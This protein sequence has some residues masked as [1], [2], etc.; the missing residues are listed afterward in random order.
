MA[1]EYGLFWN[2]RGG[3]RKY[4]AD[5]FSD[6]LK[7]FFTTGVFNGDLFV[8][9]AE[10]MDITVSPGYVN[11]DGKVMMWEGTQTFTLDVAYAEYD[12]VDAVVVERDSGERRFI[13]KVIKGGIDGVAPLPQRDGTIYQVVLA[14]ISVEHGATEI[15]QAEITDKRS[16]SN[17]CGW[18]AGTVEEIN[19]DQIVAQWQTYYNNFKHS[20]MS[21]WLNWS[22]NM[23]ASYEAWVEIRK[24][25]WLEW[26]RF[27]EQEWADWSAAQRA[28]WALWM[29][30]QEADI[31][32][33]KLDMET[34]FE[35][36][37]ANMQ[38]EYNNLASELHD[39]IDGE[40]AAILQEQIDELKA[41][42]ADKSTI[43][44][45]PAIV[46]GTYVYDGTEKAPTITGLDTTHTTVTGTTRSTLAGDFTFTI[47]LNDPESMLWADMTTA[48]IVTHW[49]VQEKVIAI[50]YLT[51]KEL[52]YDGYMKAPTVHDLDTDWVNVTG[53]LDAIS[54]GVYPVTFSLKDAG[55]TKW[56]DNTR[57]DK[58]DSWE[59]IEKL[60]VIPTLSDA[61]K[62]YNGN[63]Q[64]PTITNPDSDYLTVSGVTSA[65]NAGTYTITFSLNDP[66][67]F[68]WTDQTTE[69]KTATWT[70]ERLVVTVPTVSDTSKVYNT[71]EQAPT[72]SSPS[73]AYISVGGTPAATNA[74]NYTIT[75]NLAS[76]NNMVWSDTTTTEKTAAWRIA[77]AEQTLTLS[78]SA[79]LLDSTTPNAT[80]T[81]TFLGDGEVTATSSDTT[82]VTTT[83][84]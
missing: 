63:Q 80:V 71:Q 76:P 26:V 14:Y 1:E 17:L 32:A 8:E 30:Q 60:V 11:I 64:S 15:T 37:S 55:N 31:E 70:I 59:I 4:H 53:R 36:W 7:K 65:T 58:T 57:S 61:Q 33:F 9:S 54:V 43:V 67:N 13:V 23:Q 41:E 35:G 46:V 66:E 20:Q 52:P 79:V 28:A 22:A 84:S 44:Q 6:W 38:A 24:D 72:V 82:V 21:D 69:D 68:Q 51:D 12:R 73:A 48:P 18:V 50:P 81:A 34:D 16:D 2:S 78:A 74:G 47:S 5:S 40:A 45:I 62:T 83:V 29:S 56:A 49:S 42:I 25:G 3:D 19:F 10:G 27:H 75:F 39:L 77:K